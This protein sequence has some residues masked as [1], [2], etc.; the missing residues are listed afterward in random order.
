[1]SILRDDSFI[2]LGGLSWLIFFDIFILEDNPYVST[3][4]FYGE[5]SFEKKLLEVSPLERI[6]YDY[7]MILWRLDCLESGLTKADNFIEGEQWLFLI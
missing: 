7:R 2:L 4:L 3:R 6:V 5:E 1:M